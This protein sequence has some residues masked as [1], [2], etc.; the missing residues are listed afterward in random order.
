M[1]QDEEIENKGYNIN[2]TSNKDCM[3][4]LYSYLEVACLPKG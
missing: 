4:V 1:I 3:R 2:S